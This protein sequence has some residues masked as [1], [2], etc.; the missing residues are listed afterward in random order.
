MTKMKPLSSVY[1]S[2]L[3]FLVAVIFFVVQGQA[4]RL[5]LCECVNNSSDSQSMREFVRRNIAHGAQYC[6]MQMTNQW[7]VLA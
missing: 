1:I 6:T 5:R 4:S 7:R 2:I 3:L